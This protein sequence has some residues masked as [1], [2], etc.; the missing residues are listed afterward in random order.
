MLFLALSSNSLLRAA[1]LLTLWGRGYVEPVVAPPEPR[2]I[3][4][5][6]I[7]AYCL[8]E[9]G[10]LRGEWAQQWNGLA[11]FD[12]SGSPILA[13]LVERGFLDVDGEVLFIGP[14]AEAKFGHRHFSGMTAVFTAPPQFA[15]LAGRQEIGRCDPMLLTERVEGPRLLL[16]A[17]RSWRV[18]WVDWKRRRCQ[19]EP[20]D[21]G[22]KAK[23]VT[24][25][26]N[27]DHFEMVRAARDVLLGEDPPVQL[28]DRALRGLAEVRDELVHA[29]HPGGTVIERRDGDVRWWT[30]AGY[31]TN[32]TLAATL[33]DVVDEA[34]RVDDL[35]L[36][37]R[38]D[39][40]R[41]LW[42]VATADASSRLCLPA[43]DERALNGLK[44]NEALPQRLAEATLAQRLAALTEAE[45]VVNEPTRFAGL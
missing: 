24:P 40:T 4:A 14:S 39:L 44:F 16:L 18:T 21:R 32:L 31:R 23:W 11:P 1:G 22:G 41:E 27:G 5:Q 36:R 43:V 6:Q 34:Q 26:G 25:P 9:H 13:Y 38:A 17:G 3:V 30:W 35:G 45:G 2:H 7:L 15:V 42:A 33:S 19:V 8:Q 29:A 37:L 10:V 12:A 20:A 28:T